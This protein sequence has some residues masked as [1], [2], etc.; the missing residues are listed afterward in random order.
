MP[1]PWRRALSA[2]SVATLAGSSSLAGFHASRESVPLP[3]TWDKEKAV[4]GASR[5]ARDSSIFD[6]GFHASRD[7]VPLPPTSDR[8]KAVGGASTPLPANC[9]AYEFP[10]A[11]APGPYATPGW[12]DLPIDL[13]I[14]I[15]HLLELPEALAFRAVCPSWRS[16]S[17][18]AGSVPPR[19]SPW[20]V[21]LA[22]EPLP[23]QDPQRHAW[24]RL[25]E[26]AAASELRSLLDTERTIKVSFPHGQVVALCGAS[27]G[28]LI[29]ANKLSDLV[30]YKPFTA[31]LVPLPPIIGFD[32][33]IEGVYGDDEGKTLMGYRYGCYES[34]R[35][36]NLQEVGWHF[37][38]KVVL[39]GSPSAGRAFA[40]AIY[41]DGRRLSFARVGDARWQQVS[42]TRRRDDSFADCVYH[43]R[44]FYAITMR[45]RLKCLDF[46]GPGELW[47][48]TVIA[49]DDDIDGVITR[50][51]V[52]TPW[53]RLLQLRVILDKHQVNNVRV[54]IDRLDMKSQKMV[55]LSLGKALRGHSAF[56]GQNNPGLLSPK[57]FPE[58]KP[59]CIYF[60]TPRL[61]KHNVSDKCHNEWKGV[62]VY[63]L[64][65]R[66]LDAAFTPG[67]GDHGAWCPF[68]V[69]FTP[70]R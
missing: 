2:G 64:K 66:T 8:E 33:C 44:R 25:W 61:T 46:G 63:D 12:S 31:E 21:S 29:T 58:L 40:L 16:A 22:K 15:L 19:R 57:E 59:D 11:D 39:S 70:S 50:Y 47:M 43:R 13:L 28:W 27:H 30:L 52:S 45:G 23:S 53:G 10:K 42:R 54:E 69:W 7:S 9:V 67:A 48:E 20:L 37:Y 35:V 14:R 4:G 62:K 26:P 60:T 68:E 3:P 18:A 38:D 41:L 6:D 55:R 34:G 24:R 49:K 1:L 17:T 32:S 36:Y 56:V 51:L 65:K 5:E